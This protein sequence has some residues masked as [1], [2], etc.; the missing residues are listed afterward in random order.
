MPNTLQ[1]TDAEPEVLAV[2]DDS[3]LDAVSGGLFFSQD[4]QGFSLLSIGNNQGFSLL[5]IGNN[6]GFSLLSIG[7]IDLN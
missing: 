7:N 4:S 6:Q 1:V 5:S 3:D 2:L